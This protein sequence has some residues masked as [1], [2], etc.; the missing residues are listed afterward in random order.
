VYDVDTVQPKQEWLDIYYSVKEDLG[1]L[2]LSLKHAP[3]PSR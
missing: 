3:R 1:R 2:G